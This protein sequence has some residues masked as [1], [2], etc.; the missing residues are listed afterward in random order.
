MSLNQIPRFTS[1]DKWGF[2]DLNGDA[3]MTDLKGTL[4][5]TT[6]NSALGSAVIAEVAAGSQLLYGRY[7]TPRF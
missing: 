6:A 1:K 3:I 7:G 2:S 4:L 5:V